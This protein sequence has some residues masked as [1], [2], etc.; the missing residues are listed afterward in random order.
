MGSQTHVVLKMFEVVT[1]QL[2]DDSVLLRRLCLQFH[3]LHPQRAELLLKG[4]DTTKLFGLHDHHIVRAVHCII[5]LE[6]KSVDRQ[7]GRIHSSTYHGLDVCHRMVQP[8][9]NDPHQLTTRIDRLGV[10]PLVI[11]PVPLLRA[12]LHLSQIGRAHV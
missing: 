7:N 2:S 10:W 6:V 4:L 5:R 11:A 9:T 3:H 1:D 8:G 12:S